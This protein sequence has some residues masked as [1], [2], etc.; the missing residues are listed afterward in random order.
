MTGGS[1][2]PLKQDG[3]EQSASEFTAF[4]DDATGKDLEATFVGVTAV[5]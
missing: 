3:D 2:D 1:G 5:V 4:L